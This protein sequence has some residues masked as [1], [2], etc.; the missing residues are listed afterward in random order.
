MLGKVKDRLSVSNC[1]ITISQ[2]VKLFCK[3][4]IEL[5]SHKT[6]H[7][8]FKSPM[9]IFGSST[10]ENAVVTVIENK[11]FLLGAISDDQTLVICKVIV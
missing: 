8:S 9:N 1:S 4:I 7:E 2:I 5:S 11:S 6:V 3:K 10:A